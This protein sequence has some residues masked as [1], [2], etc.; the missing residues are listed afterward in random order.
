[1]IDIH[2]LQKT[3]AILS[4]LTSSG[5]SGRAYPE[6]MTNDRILEPQCDLGISV[7]LNETTGRGQHQRR[8][9]HARTPFGKEY[10]RRTY[11]DPEE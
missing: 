3:I 4:V 5:K 8:Y 9:S 11:R 7:V 2:M 1:M 6:Q 10:C